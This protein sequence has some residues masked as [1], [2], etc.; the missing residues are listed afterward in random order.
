MFDPSWQSRSDAIHRLVPMWTQG[1][2]H[3]QGAL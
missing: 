1:A 2:S 3:H